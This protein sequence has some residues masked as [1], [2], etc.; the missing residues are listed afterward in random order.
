MT[1]PKLNLRDLFWL[2]VVVAMGLGWYAQH[3]QTMRTI[4]RFSPM[5]YEKMTGEEVQ[6]NRLKV[7]PQEKSS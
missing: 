3:R 6:T 4:L 1:L 2:V 7:H 5:L